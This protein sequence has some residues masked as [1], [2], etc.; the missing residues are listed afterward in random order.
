MAR[1]ERKEKKKLVN[2]NGQ[3]TRETRK[4]H[5]LFWFVRGEW[6]VCFFFF[7]FR[8]FSLF[9]FR[10]VVVWKCLSPTTSPSSSLFRGSARRKHMSHLL[11]DT[12]RTGFFY[13]FFFVRCGINSW[14][15][16][17]WAAAATAV[18]YKSRG[19]GQ[20]RGAMPYLADVSL[21]RST[22][23]FHPLCVLEKEE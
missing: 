13:F 23:T 14:Y 7:F 18:S 9:L 8:V 15:C 17:A 3:A 22:C 19:N 20:K 12:S 2:E 10:S 6:F 5:A 11:R 21:S 4:G 1:E 16:L